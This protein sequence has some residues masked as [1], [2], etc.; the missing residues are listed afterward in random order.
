MKLRIHRAEVVRI[1]L[2]WHARLGDAIP[3]LAAKLEEGPAAFEAAWLAYTAES[4][5]AVE[6]ELEC[7]AE[8]APRA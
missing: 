5:A 7:A 6:L 8:G 4:L 1:L 3:E 2:A